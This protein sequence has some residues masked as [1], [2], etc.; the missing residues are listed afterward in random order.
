MRAV[1]TRSDSDADLDRDVVAVDRRGVTELGAYAIGNLHRAF[2]GVEVAQ[3]QRVFVAAEPGEAVF[4]ANEWCDSGRDLDEYRVARRVPERVVDRLEAIDVEE[5]QPDDLARA[6]RLRHGRFE[7][8]RERGP[9]A[10]TGEAVVQRDLGELLV[11]VAQLTAQTHLTGDDFVHLVVHRAH[12]DEIDRERDPEH[13]GDVIRA[14]E[15]GQGERHDQRDLI[16]VVTNARR[17]CGDDP[18][19]R[20]REAEQQDHRA[21]GAVLRVGKR[22]PR[23]ARPRE[24]ECDGGDE[25]DRP[26]GDHGVPAAQAVPERGEERGDRQ[27]RDEREPE[28][29]PLERYRA[30]D[31]QDQHAR[32][33]NAEDRP[34]Q[35]HRVDVVEALAGDAR[36]RCGLFHTYLSSNQGA[37][38]TPNLS[39]R[40]RRDSAF[41]ANGPEA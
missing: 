32:A 16:R 31:Q 34:A 14:E 17:A 35:H 39:P 36:R 25:S 28:Q 30:P 29:P 8:L 4:G 15:V 38:R 20:R 24:P 41:T 10:Q 21:R 37:R 33:G 3:E 27:D 13:L 7:R 19:C 23:H 26:P 9:A 2:R 18:R 11:C 1:L 5:Q 40:I 12:T 22:D 6:L